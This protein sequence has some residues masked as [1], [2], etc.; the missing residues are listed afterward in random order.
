MAFVQSADQYMKTFTT[1]ENGALTHA[2]FGGDYEPFMEIFFHLVRNKS[3]NKVEELFNNAYKVNPVYTLI[4]LFH[5]RDP[6]KGN[7][8][9]GGKGERDLFYYGFETLQPKYKHK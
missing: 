5:L 3:K 8:G 4:L 1:T 7:D 2:S 6:R 9:I